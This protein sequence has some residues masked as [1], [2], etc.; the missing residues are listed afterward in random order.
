VPNNQSVTNGF[1]AFIL[2]QTGMQSV[3][4]RIDISFASP[5][6]LPNNVLALGLQVQ[7]Y[8]NPAPTTECL[9]VE[10]QV[11]VTFSDSLP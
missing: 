3:S 1:G 11:T 2:K 7:S 10:V 5:I 4:E 6:A 9:D 8:P